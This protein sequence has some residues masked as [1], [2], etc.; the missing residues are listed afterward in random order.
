MHTRVVTYTVSDGKRTHLRTR[1]EVYWSWDTIG[2]SRLDAKKVVFSGKT[3]PFSK[4]EFPGFCRR[5]EIVKTG[6]HARTVFYLL[7]KHMH[8]SVFTKLEN[9]T[10]SDGTEFLED[11]PLGRLFEDSV[12]SIANAVFWAIYI[13]FSILL[14]VIFFYAENRWLED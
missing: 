3:L 11:V 1:T 10:V 4:F 9:G 7:P 5:E 12:S 2:S 13:V 8:G 6:Y 14:M